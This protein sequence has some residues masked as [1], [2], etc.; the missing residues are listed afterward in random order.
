MAG[1]EKL[2]IT[3]P[4][5]L[6]EMVRE[7]VR[8]GDY[9]SNSEVIRDALRLWQEHEDLKDRKRQWL[10]DKIGRSLADPGP[11]LDAGDVFAELEGRYGER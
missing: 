2:S 5:D 9:A 10:R 3:L 8:A 1:A 7:R 11:S 4:H 6:A